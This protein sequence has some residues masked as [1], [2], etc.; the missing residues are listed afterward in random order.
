M[1]ERQIRIQ[2]RQPKQT[3]EKS[4]HTKKQIGDHPPCPSSLT[5]FCAHGSTPRIFWFFAPNHRT[6]LTQPNTVSCNHTK[7]HWFACAFCSLKRKTSCHLFL[8]PFDHSSSNNESIIGD[9]T[10]SKATQHHRVTQNTQNLP[11]LPKKNTKKK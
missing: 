9:L 6:S 7:N 2:Q 1:K 11:D 5:D 4:R 8:R 10:Q 3:G